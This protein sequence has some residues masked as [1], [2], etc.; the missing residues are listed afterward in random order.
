MILRV[1][2]KLGKK[3]K[4]APDMSLPMHEDPFL[5]WSGHV[6]R[7]NRVQHIIL[8]NT[9]TLY[10]LVFLGRGLTSPDAYERRVRAELRTFMTSH[11]YADVYAEHIAADDEGAA[12]SKALNQSVIGSVNDMIF[13]ATLHIEYYGRSLEAVRDRINT[14]PMG[15]L[16]MDFPSRAFHALSETTGPHDRGRDGRGRYG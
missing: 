12:F 11:G 6:F 15:A 14:L 1:S 4:A 3:I 5:D 9:A 16:D 10:S 2:H 8:T 13:R 7:A